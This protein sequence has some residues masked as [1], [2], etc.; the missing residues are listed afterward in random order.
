MEEMERKR[1]EMG[2]NST[3]VIGQQANK[4][5][6]FLLLCKDNEKFG[7]QWENAKQLYQWNQ[8]WNR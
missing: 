2:E 8:L 3:L 6:I 4:S 5:N 1:G 7:V